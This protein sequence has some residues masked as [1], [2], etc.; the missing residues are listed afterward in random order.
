MRGFPGAE[1]DV[2]LQPPARRP[3]R[4]GLIHV[5]GGGRFRPTASVVAD[6]GQAG[7][8]GAGFGANESCSRWLRV[9]VR[10]C[11]A[12]GSGGHDNRHHHDRLHV[13]LKRSHKLQGISLLR[14]RKILMT[15]RFFQVR[16]RFPAPLDIEPD[17]VGIAIYFHFNLW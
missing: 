3:A 4:A 2:A 1:L 12:G 11:R 7:A 8:L 13:A 17:S 9:V 16:G 6:L 14:C 5:H 15:A 10:F